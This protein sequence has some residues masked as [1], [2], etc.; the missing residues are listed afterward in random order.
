MQMVSYS[1]NFIMFVIRPSGIVIPERK[2]SLN[3]FR[4]FFFGG[5]EVITKN[6]QLGMFLS[7]KFFSYVPVTDNSVD[8]SCGNCWYHFQL[9]QQG[10][11]VGEYVR[12]RAASNFVFSKPIGRMW[13]KET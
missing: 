13:T 8:W 5:G 11:M 3:Q 9:H 1:P 7:D 4:Q 2:N 10:K 6:K 12:M